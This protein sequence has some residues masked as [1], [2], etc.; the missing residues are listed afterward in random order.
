MEKSL[1][2][3][4]KPEN[5]QIVQKNG[6]TNIIIKNDMAMIVEMANDV[7][8]K[9]KGDF[10][11]LADGEM[12]FASKNDLHFDSVDSKLYLNSRQSTLLK[13][14]PES[15]AYRTKQELERSKSLLS[16]YKQ[17]EF[18]LL[19]KDRVTILEQQI[20]ELKCRE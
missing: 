5:V 20:K 11:I 4:L 7:M 12:S 3:V 15:I 9:T 16:A 2:L 13:D 1:T 19:L 18:T 6:L 8:L 14:K 17:Q 10:H